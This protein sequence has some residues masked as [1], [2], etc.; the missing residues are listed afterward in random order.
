MN[1][2]VIFEKPQPHHCDPQWD[3]ATGGFRRPVRD[4]TTVECTC[5]QVYVYDVARQAPN[6]ALGCDARAWRKER[7]RERRRRLDAT[8]EAKK[9]R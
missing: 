2:R 7:R 4:G 1:G 3:G 8:W 5:G 6:F 9:Q